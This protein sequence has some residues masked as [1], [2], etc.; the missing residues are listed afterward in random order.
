MTVFA[1]MCADPNQL[2]D[3]QGRVESRSMS[4][5]MTWHL[6]EHPSLAL[7]L[8]TITQEKQTERALH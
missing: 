6:Y 7:Q 2:L 1:Y 3:S 5:V 4:S 8:Y